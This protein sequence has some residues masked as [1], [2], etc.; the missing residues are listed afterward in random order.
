MHEAEAVG[1]RWVHFRGGCRVAAPGP[2]HA[3]RDLGEIVAVLTQWIGPEG[4]SSRRTVRGNNLYGYAATGQP[5][6][7][8]RPP[9]GSTRPLLLTG[10]LECEDDLRL[11]E[12]HGW[13]VS[14]HAATGDCARCDWIG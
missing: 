6:W 11:H 14:V 12:A 9:S 2:V 1:G 7:R 10:F 8:V 3:I 13:W 5:L 4:R